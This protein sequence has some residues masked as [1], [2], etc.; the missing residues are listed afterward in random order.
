MV[1]EGEVEVL[2]GPAGEQLGAQLA[3]LGLLDG[4]VDGGE[5]GAHPVEAEARLD[6]G[7]VQLV[8][9]GERQALAGV[10]CEGVAEQ[11][12]DVDDGLRRGRVGRGSAAACRPS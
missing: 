1:G 6:D 9:V 10:R 2:D 5:R 12:G 11:V 3:L 4:R 8:G 7:V